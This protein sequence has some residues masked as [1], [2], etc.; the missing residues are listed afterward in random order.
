MYTNHFSHRNHVTD[1]VSTLVISQRSLVWESKAEIVPT[2]AR[3]HQGESSVAFPMPKAS[4]EW[5]HIQG[6][7][8]PTKGAKRGYH[9]L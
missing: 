6:V 5:L 2:S 4:F 9:P 7:P 3:S 8:R 1:L